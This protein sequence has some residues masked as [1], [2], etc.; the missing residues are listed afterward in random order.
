LKALARREGD[1]K[2][3]SRLNVRRLLGLLERTHPGDGL[4]DVDERSLERAIGELPDRWRAIV[5]RCD[6]DRELHQT[7]A[8]DL[9]ISKR[10]FYRERNKALAFLSECLCASRSPAR[11]EVA[12]DVDDAVGGVVE[13]LFNTRSVERAVPILEAALCDVSAPVARFRLLVK[14]AA[15]HAQCGA[16]DEAAG[17]LRLAHQILLEVSLERERFQTLQLE[18][19]AEEANLLRHRQDPTSAEERLREVICCCVGLG[20]DGPSV[21]RAFAV[22]ALALAN[23]L[24]TQE[25]YV[26]AVAFASQAERTLRSYEYDMA[27][28]S[29]AMTQLATMRFFGGVTPARVVLADLKAAYA[30]AQTNGFAIDLV[31]LSTV[32]AFLHSYAGR[33]DEALAYGRSTVNIARA[34][35]LRDA[36][37]TG[38]YYTLAS[39]QIAAG[40]ALAAATSLQQLRVSQAKHPESV[41]PFTDFLEAQILY[42]GGRY[43]A[44]LG[45]AETA[46]GTS[47]ESRYVRTQGAALELRATIEEKLGERRSARESLD[48]AIA[49]LERGAPAGLLGKAYARS[50]QLTGNARHRATSLVLRQSASL[51]V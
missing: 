29:R 25:R 3:T 26:E 36:F 7:V 32:L 5:V 10:H 38:A 22:V 21:N 44:A 11:V 1:Q 33:H 50:A 4:R 45:S 20:I 41:L 46:I 12:F 27:L 31:Q 19:A 51:S 6:L 49:L 18:L 48:V 24:G 23:L 28:R 47:E 37:T 30:I 13:H 14:L 39:A 35:N 34:A 40:N 16:L 42:A 17:K 8:A 2:V 15:A 43:R 9:G